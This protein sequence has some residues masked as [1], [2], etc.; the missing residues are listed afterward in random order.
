MSIESYMEIQSREERIERVRIKTEERDLEIKRLKGLIH[1]VYAENFCDDEIYAALDG[2]IENCRRDYVLVKDFSLAPAAFLTIA[3]VDK[4]YQTLVF[5]TEGSG[6]R[7]KFLDLPLD[8][9]WSVSGAELSDAEIVETAR[10]SGDRIVSPAW[11][12]DLIN[13]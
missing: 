3:A 11:V 10:Q 9:Q 5:E 13:K 6:S 1:K 12:R 2:L 7:I 4:Y 8:W